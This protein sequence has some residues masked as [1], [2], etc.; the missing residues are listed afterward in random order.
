M[1]EL[2]ESSPLGIWNLSLTLSILFSAFLKSLISAS[3]SSELSQKLDISS[4][5]W[6]LFKLSSKTSDNALSIDLLT[7]SNWS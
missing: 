4:K 2:I 1:K 6:T 7:S 5:S 3:P